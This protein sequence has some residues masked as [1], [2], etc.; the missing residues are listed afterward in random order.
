MQV[1]PL[2]PFLRC[3]LV[4]V[5]LKKLCGLAA[6][7]GSSGAQLGEVSIWC[8]DTSGDEVM[9]RGG[10][11]KGAG[12]SWAVARAARSDT[13]A[14][15]ATRARRDSSLT[16]IRFASCSCSAAGL[17]AAHSLAHSSL[18]TRL[19]LSPTATPRSTRYS[20]HVVQRRCSRRAS[21]LARGRRLHSPIHIRKLTPS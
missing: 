11:P 16:S 13:A 19:A 7:S 15:A 1:D 20:C 4:T 14:A 18:T 9:M 10:L 5:C 12:R 21:L 2:P 6:V 17:P 3:L 8:N